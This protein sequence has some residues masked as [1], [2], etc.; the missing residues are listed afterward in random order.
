MTYGRR[1]GIA[2]YGAR[3]RHPNGAHIEPGSGVL[4]ERGETKL[5]LAQYTSPSAKHRP[6]AARR[7]CMLHRYPD[8]VAGEKI[9]QKRLP[10]ALRTGSRPSRSSSRPDARDELCV[11]ELASVIWAVQMSTSVHRGTRGGPTPSVRTSCA[12]TSTPNGHRI[13]RVQ[14]G[15][16]HRA[17][18]ARRAGR[19]GLGP[20]RPVEGPARVRADR[21]GLRFR[22]CAGRRWPSPARSSGASRTSS[23]PS[24]GRRARR[25]DLPRLQPERRDRTIASAYSV[26]G[27]PHGPVSAP[28]TWA[29][30]ARRRDGRLHHRHHAGR[31]PSWAIC[32][33]YRRPR[34]GRSRRCSSWPTATSATTAWAIARTPNYP[35]MPGDHPL[36]PSK[37]NRQLDGDA[38]AAVQPSSSTEIAV[39]ELS[40]LLR[41]GKEA[42][43]DTVAR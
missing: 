35:K 22:R 37:M 39:F 5:D 10:K 14:A 6:G 8:G 16:G 36:Q 41:S 27:R 18:G 23:P 30:F 29:E 40:L 28:V 4:P 34:C 31:S 20:R 2:I 9:Y 43:M 25:A 26:R 7:P 15:G 33:R 3:N 38:S 11:T 1:Y 19:G 32:T 42:R 24:G 21:A 13:R 12:S 17:R